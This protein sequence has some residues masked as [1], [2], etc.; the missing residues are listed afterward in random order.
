MQHSP[1]LPRFWASFDRF[2]ATSSYL[3]AVA[4]VRFQ[5]AMGVDLR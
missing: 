5:P 4:H 2:F 3:H 1:V